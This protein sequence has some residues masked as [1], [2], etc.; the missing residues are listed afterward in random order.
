MRLLDRLRTEKLLSFTLILFTL[1]VGIVIGTLVNSGVK[2]AKATS[3]AAAPDA[4]PLVIPNPVQLSTAFSQIAKQLEPSVVNISTTY[5]PKAV[6]TR[7][8]AKRRA[9]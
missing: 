6:A 7:P 8:H 9:T 4:T 5:E 2:T 1:S 3:S